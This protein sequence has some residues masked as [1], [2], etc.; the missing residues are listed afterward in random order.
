[1]RGCG[2]DRLKIP[3]HPHSGLSHHFFSSSFT[4]VH[5]VLNKPTLS[6][7]SSLAYKLAKLHTRP[8]TR[9]LHHQHYHHPTTGVCFCGNVPSGR[10]I[11]GKAR[12]SLGKA[13]KRRAK[14]QVRNVCNYRASYCI[15]PCWKRSQETLT[16]Y[17]ALSSTQKRFS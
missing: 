2:P 11:F 5:F 15:F 14:G 1:M 6:C 7:A 9:L 13:A 4:V 3:S 12:A 17:S 8:N 10:R 16:L